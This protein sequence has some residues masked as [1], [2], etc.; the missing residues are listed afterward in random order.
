MRQLV[1]VGAVT[2][3]QN[4]LIKKKWVGSAISE[5]SRNNPGMGIFRKCD[6]NQREWRRER[7]NPHR[8]VKTVHKGRPFGGF[9]RFIFRLTAAGRRWFT[10][11]SSAH[12]L[13]SSVMTVWF[14]EGNLLLRS[15]RCVDLMW[16]HDSS[17]AQIEIKRFTFNYPR[18]VSI[19]TV[20]MTDED[21]VW[22]WFEQEAY[23]HQRVGVLGGTTYLTHFISE[24]DAAPVD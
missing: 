6:C 2:F 10:P 3:P 4:E 9:Y 19:V 16:Q 15:P 24:G 14:N 7:V 22:F 18:R 1:N 8:R 5:G 17:G 23:I 13:D 11:P 21:S 12:C 20:V